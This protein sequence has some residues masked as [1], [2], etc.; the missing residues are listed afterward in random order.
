MKDF[1]KLEIWQ[2]GMDLADRVYDI[3]E[4]IPWRTGQKLIDQLGASSLSIPSNIAEGNSRRSEK[5]KFRFMEIAL[6]SA[7]ELETQIL[8]A[9]RRKWSTERKINAALEM[10]R[11]E[12]QKLHGFMAVL[13]P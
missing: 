1:K 6:G 5:D 12:Q 11:S 3:I 13:K 4:D 9:E 8:F 2:L 7:F 10:V